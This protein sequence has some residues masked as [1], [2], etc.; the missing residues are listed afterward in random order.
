[1]GDLPTTARIAN[2]T[3]EQRLNSILQ[4]EL[5]VDSGGA[6]L[7][8]ASK[9]ENLWSRGH[10]DEAVETLGELER[11][12]DRLA[13]GIQWLLPVES[14]APLSNADAR[15]GTASSAESA[16][17]DWDTESGKI[18][19][20]V[21]WGTDGGWSINVSDDGGASWTE[22]YLWCC[23]F[24]LADMAVVDE[25]VYVGY[26]VGSETRLRRASIST[27]QIDDG[28]GFSDNRRQLARRSDRDQSGHQ[29]RR[30]Q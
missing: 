2:L 24:E 29:R 4:I 17:L 1:M 15:V 16:S 11:A 22:T 20:L 6:Q 14:G 26:T 9:A 23:G 13:I 7:A 28:Y 3:P 25:Y 12:E 30:R 27:N 5:A 10:F 19:T 8:L 18:Y 21:D